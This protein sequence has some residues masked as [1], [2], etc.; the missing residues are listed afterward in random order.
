ML[1]LTEEEGSGGGLV[2]EANSRSGGSCPCGA[3]S[4]VTS[5]FAEGDTLTPTHTPGYRGHTWLDL[6][7]N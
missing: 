5:S 7:K 4:V 2:S 6:R 1:C 3:S